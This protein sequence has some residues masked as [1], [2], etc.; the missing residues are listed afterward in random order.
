MPLE[1]CALAGAGQ[2]DCEDDRTLWLTS[3]RRG[4][5]LAGGSS[6]S[7]RFSGSARF[8]FGW[9]LGHGGFEWDIGS[10]ATLAG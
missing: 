7:S 8:P 1:P 2:P 3:A 4:L 10:F 6:G 5:G 9:L